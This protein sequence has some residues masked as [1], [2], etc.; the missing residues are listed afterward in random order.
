MKNETN[1]IPN[2]KDAKLWDAIFEKFS[3]VLDLLDASADDSGID[4]LVYEIEN[5]FE[6]L[7]TEGGA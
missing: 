7:L 5:R 1:Y 2:L 4:D 6:Q 3:F